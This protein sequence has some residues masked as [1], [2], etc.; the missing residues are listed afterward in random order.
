V[1]SQIVID[2]K[3]HPSRVPQYIELRNRYVELL[4]STPVQLEETR[5]WLDGGGIEVRC[6][7]EGEAMIGSVV[8]YLAKGGEV[9]F[10]V[11]EPGKGVGTRLL[12]IIEEVA[13]EKRQ[14]RIWSWVLLSNEPAKMA[15]LKSGFIQE[16]ISE[17]VYRGKARK[18]FLFG[19]NLGLGRY[20]DG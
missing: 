8:L 7:V 1:T 14:D 13:K 12:R 10:F 6:L 15:F 16:K 3:E 17:R 9:A 20:A 19:K 4:L 2:L 11:K 18:G 5:R